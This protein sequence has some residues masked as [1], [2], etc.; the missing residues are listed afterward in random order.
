MEEKSFQV[1]NE[2]E[3]RSKQLRSIN[4]ILSKVDERLT[5]LEIAINHTAKCNEIN[6]VKLNEMNERSML[7]QDLIVTMLN[8]IVTRLTEIESKLGVNPYA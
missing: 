3:Q 8:G 6:G 5:K 4:D 2:R 7:Q 1:N